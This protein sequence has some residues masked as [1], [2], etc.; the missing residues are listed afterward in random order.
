MSTPTRPDMPRRPVP[1]PGTGRAGA[2]RA[3]QPL[4]GRPGDRCPGE[5]RVLRGL[6][7]PPA[8]PPERRP[9][10]A[11]LTRRVTGAGTRT[12]VVG[13]PGIGKSRLLELAVRAAQAEGVRVL[14]VRAAGGGQPF[15]G[16]ADLLLALPEALLEA[17]PPVQRAAVDVALARRTVDRPLPPTALRTAVA[18]LVGALLADGPVCLA[19]DDW[20]LLDPESAVVLRHVLDRPARAGRAPSLL[21]TQRMDGVLSGEQDRVEGDL[22][23]P[24][25]VLP[26]PPLTACSL[27][28]LVTA[29][30]GHPWS[31]AAVA[32]LHRRTGGNPL[33]AAEL[34]HPQLGRPATGAEEVGLPASL[35]GVLA[36]R[37]RRLAPGALTALAVV[38][39]LGSTPPETL[40][41]LVP[42][43][44]DA[45]VDALE[46]GVLRCTGRGLEP[47]H[48]LLGTAAL[49]SLGP[50]GRM[51]LHQRLAEL[52]SSAGERA[53]HLHL[54]VPPGA[55]EEVAVAFDRAVEESRS[56]GAL[57][58]A[59]VQAEH[60]LARSP[61]GTP[62]LARRAVDAA[63]LAFAAG[64][65]DR[66][67]EL[68]ADLPL[69]DLPIQVLDRGLPLL[70]DS[71][72]VRDGERRS[73]DLLPR[74]LA[75]QPGPTVTAVVDAYRAEDGALS[76]AERRACAVSSVAALTDS[77]RA[78]VSLHR[79]LTNLVQ[80]Q[81]DSGEGLDRAL[82]DRAAALEDERIPVSAVDSAGT[83]LAMSAVQVDDVATAA[84]ALERLIEQ[85]TAAGED[86][87]VA[88]FSFH[89]ALVALVAGDGRRAAALVAA[90]EH[91]PP[92]AANPPP[93]VLRA[94]GLLAV[95][96][97]DAGRLQ[98]LLDQP[99]SSGSAA[100]H[101]WTRLALRGIAAAR[102]GDWAA[103][104]EPLSTA[105]RL[106]EAAGVREPGRR[107]W[108]DAELGETLAA[109]DRTEDAEQVADR[110]AEVAAH[111]SRPLVR[112]QER[113][114]RGLVAAARG[115]L[116]G[117][118]Q[119]MEESVAV[120]ATSG[121]PVE[122]ARSLVELGRLLRRRRA[123][124]R[125]R[126]LFEQA[127][128]SAVAAG[129]VPLQRR[130]EHELATSVGTRAPTVLTATERRI[131]AAVAT[132]ATNREIASAQFISVRTVESH[133]ASVYRKLG[134][135][136][137]T[138]LARALAAA[139]EDAA[140]P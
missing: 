96:S 40:A 133:L 120:L 30:T 65:L 63:G 74:L 37:T 85:A 136:S 5:G 100:V 68:L 39:A 140:T 2:V 116:A 64:D 91:Q 73:L 114:V 123:R 49:E 118:Q 10:L 28:A 112:G 27:A 4:E 81:L 25:D 32:E 78:P 86:A 42:D 66:V 87:T 90:Q 58:A 52:A 13:E 31:A 126:A 98:A 113:R 89:L 70:I 137:R 8:V 80:I 56:R 19:V 41:A 134:V 110:L 24:E 3:A 95:A 23:R 21:A 15:A 77:G 107:L 101:A 33:W 9:F 129:D 1:A 12:L 92:W 14:P 104:L 103:A 18:A 61:L 44:R 106:T 105:H 127:R 125:A 20:P 119:L 76:M 46:A 130:A 128:A 109:L 82:L 83:I 11:E 122:H 48:P 16:L 72:T 79:A 88:F 67:V 117:A 51:Q 38:A 93:F 22:F 50:R 57:A 26:V 115:D 62:D 17:L 6:A 135:S 71:R 75:E 121:F 29:R 34:S 47:T 102:A 36:T 7:V 139:G 45:L 43:H 124:A 54:A 59:L 84:T 131:A 69:T 94:R 60:A 99:G 53:H 108:L 132:G 97:G 55:D 35:A 138:R 111:G